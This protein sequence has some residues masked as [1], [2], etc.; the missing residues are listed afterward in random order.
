M[1]KR[2]VSS[3]I[4]TPYAS[5]EGA[6]T[7]GKTREKLRYLLGR[8]VWGGGEVGRAAAVVPLATPTAAFLPRS[9]G[10]IRSRWRSRR[11][12]GRPSPAGIWARCAACTWP[13]PPAAPRPSRIRTWRSCT[14]DGRSSGRPRAPR[15][16]TALCPTRSRTRPRVCGSA[17]SAGCEKE[18]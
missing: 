7:K 10:P 5:Y 12:T 17:T 2:F 18:K 11:S 13:A 1:S 14:W 3:P 9:A 6:P 4:S 8:V 16:G 15:T